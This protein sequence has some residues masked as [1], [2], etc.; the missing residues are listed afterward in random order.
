MN[1]QK[2]E[3]IKF[4]LGL[5]SS[6]DVMSFNDMQILKEYIQNY[7][8]ESNYKYALLSDGTQEE[9]LYRYSCSLHDLKVSFQKAKKTDRFLH[10]QVSSVEYQLIKDDYEVITLKTL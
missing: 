8:L 10:K 9:E 3:Q 4:I 1:S 7:D 5:Q 2:L 6:C